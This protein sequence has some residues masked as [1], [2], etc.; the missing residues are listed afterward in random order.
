MRARPPLHR[1]AVNGNPAVA[2]LLLEAGA[3]VLA[4]GSTGWTVLHDVVGNSNPEVLAVLVDAGAEL[5][6]VAEFPDSHWAYGSRTPLLEAAG[7]SREPAIVT[8]LV[9]AG[10]DINA[11]VTG[12]TLPFVMEGQA[13]MTI[14]EERGAT[15]LHMAAL[16]NRNP[17]IVEALVRAG[18]DLEARDR[19]GRTALHV[20]AMRNGIVFERL[21]DLGADPAALDDEGKTPLDYARDNIGLQG[22]EEV[23]R[24]RGN[25]R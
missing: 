4:R 21:L 2:A 25:A 13:T 24:L 20:A 5:E 10:A 19:R 14:P 11:R 12:T 16:R 8:A 18:A 7:V 15:V 22:L 23:M 3:D 9:E 17:E 1:A 6:A